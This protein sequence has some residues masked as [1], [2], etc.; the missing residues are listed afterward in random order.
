MTN[1][2]GF[3]RFEILTVIVLIMCIFAFLMYSILGGAD[4]QK[5]S[6]MIDD[7]IN[8]SK[9]VSTNSNSFHNTETIYLDEVINEG[10]ISK[11]KSPFSSKS[12]DVTE[13]KIEYI[14]GYPY[15]TLKCDNY[16]IDKTKINS[17]S[18]VTIYK[19]GNWTTKKKNS[20]D[21]EKVMYNCSNN[22]KELYSSYYEELYLVSKL[23]ADNGTSYF[24]I[25]D[26]SSDCDSVSKTFYRTKEVAS[27]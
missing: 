6:T 27:E 16:L 11:M 20:D 10:L 12:C 2:F 8:F 9:V 7:A 1:N 15:V 3:G 17:K 26:A 4:N 5:F 13:S 25:D 23:N 18:N 22:G 21:E 19:V 24:F 14:D